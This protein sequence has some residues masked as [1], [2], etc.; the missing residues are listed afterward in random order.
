MAYAEVLTDLHTFPRPSREK[1]QLFGYI[2]RS[3]W[4]LDFGR[5]HN[6]D[7][8][9]VKDEFNLI[10]ESVEL[11]RGEIMKDGDFAKTGQA[12]EREG[13]RVDQATSSYGESDLQRLQYGNGESERG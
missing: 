11:I 2:L 6:V 1:A 13:K 4:I 3:G 7:P 12:V 5:K 8:E 10:M 9:D